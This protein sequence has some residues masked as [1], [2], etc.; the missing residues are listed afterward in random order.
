MGQPR[1]PD[2]IQ[3]FN[4]SKEKSELP[5]ERPKVPIAQLN[6]PRRTSK[7][8]RANVFGCV[9]N[10]LPENSLVLLGSSQISDEYF[11]CCCN[12]RDLTEI[13]KSLRSFLFE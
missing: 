6:T 4:D 2:T 7:V 1:A 10:N 8:E 13:P 9:E 3:I 12:F 5:N 11:D